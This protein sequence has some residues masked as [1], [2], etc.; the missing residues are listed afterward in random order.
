MGLDTAKHRAIDQLKSICLTYSM[1]QEMTEPEIC[2][3]LTVTE[4][5]TT[6][7]KFLQTNRNQGRPNVIGRDHGQFD[8]A[9]E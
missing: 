4:N 9:I 5:R 6:K 1:L 8:S 2:R 7:H 3:N